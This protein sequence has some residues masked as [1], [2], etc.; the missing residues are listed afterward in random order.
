[1]HRDA[2]DDREDDP[3]QCPGGSLFD[4]H[5]VGAILSEKSEV[6]SERNDQED[7][8]AEPEW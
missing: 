5:N 4:G 8:E 2:E 7:S 6:N 1:L 3:D